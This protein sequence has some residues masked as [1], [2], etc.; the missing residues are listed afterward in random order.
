MAGMFG[1]TWGL[2]ARGDQA[3]QQLSKW[4]AYRCMNAVQPFLNSKAHDA[5]LTLALH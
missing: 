3:E 1:W 4:P 5:G 2:E